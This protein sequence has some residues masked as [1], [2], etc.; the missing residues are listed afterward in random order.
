MSSY[1][2][3][4]GLIFETSICYWQDQPGS[5][6]L[7]YVPSVRVRR[8]TWHL[9]GPRDSVGKRTPHR[10]VHRHHRHHRHRARTAPRPR[11]VRARE[12]TLQA[13]GSGSSG[14]SGAGV[15]DR[16]SET[17]WLLKHRVYFEVTRESRVC[18]R[19]TPRD[20]L[21][22]RLNPR[23]TCVQTTGSLARTRP[24]DGLRRRTA[25]TDGASRSRPPS[26]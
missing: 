6:A 2:D 7:R 1:L 25:G 18:R 14:S 16:S 23:H 22:R 15:G 9:P 12:R 10:P 4:H 11:P 3:L 5:L 21:W 26:V 24:R 13:G 19:P 8:R 20:G 17:D